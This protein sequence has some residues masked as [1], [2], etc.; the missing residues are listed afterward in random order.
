[1]NMPIFVNI[2]NFYLFENDLKGPWLVIICFSEAW[3]WNMSQVV[4]IQKWVTVRKRTR[5]GETGRVGPV[6]FLHNFPIPS[7]YFPRKVVLQYEKEYMATSLETRYGQSLMNLTPA[8]QGCF[9]GIIISYSAI[10]K[11]GDTQKDL[12]YIHLEC[13]KYTYNG[14]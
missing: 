2:Y 4:E 3:V 11:W 10:C 12:G 9:I 13:H 6:S 5:G 7:S 14:Y 8:S 1:M